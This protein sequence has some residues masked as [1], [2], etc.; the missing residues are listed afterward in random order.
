MSNDE[1]VVAVTENGAGRFTTRGV[2]DVGASRSIMVFNPG[3]PHSG[4]VA[5][6]R[7]WHYRGLYID[8]M[9]QERI[10]ETFDRHAHAAPYFRNSVLSDP[11]LADLLVRAHLALEER[12][13]RL[14]RESLLLAAVVKLFERHG[15]AWRPLAAV[16][17]ERSPVL[18]A[19]AHMRANFAADLTLDDLASCAALSP[20]H[21][22]QKKSPRRWCGLRPMP[23]RSSPATISV[24]TAASSRND[25]TEVQFTSYVLILLRHGDPIHLLILSRRRRWRVEGRGD[26]V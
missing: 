12:D 1:L 21:F 6:E 10:C 8:A 14:I 24:S 20:F 5:G 17:Q 3:E 26:G 2:S 22:G 9:L 23:P 7:G 25:L 15:E 18:R 19:L 16:G 11:D 4:G 13:G